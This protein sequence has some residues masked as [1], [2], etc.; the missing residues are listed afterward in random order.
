MLAPER[1]PVI[2]GVG[3]VTVP[4]DRDAE[5]SSRPEPLDLMVRALERAAEDASGAERGGEAKAGRQLLAKLDALYAVTGFAWH[6]KNPA[7]LVAE[8]LG[9][10]PKLLGLTA[11]GGNMPQ[12]LVHQ[13]SLSITRGELEAAAVVGAECLW[14]R[15]AARRHGGHVAWAVQEDPACPEP[16]AFG[17]EQAGS[18][19]LEVE[20]GVFLPLQAYP[21]IEQAFRARTGRSPEEHQRELGKL[22]GRFAQ[23]AAAN[24]HAWIRSAPSPEEIVTPS[25]ANRM[26][27][28]P[29]TKT[30][31]ANASVDQ[32]AG[33][34]ICSLATARAAGVPEDRMVFPRSGSDANDHWYL[35]H[36]VDLGRSP[37]IE[38][39]ARN[40]L[41]TAGLTLDDV[42]LVDLYSCFPCAVELACEA[43]GLDPLDPRRAP[44]LTGGLTFMGGPGNNYVSH[45]IAAMADALRSRGEGVGL[46]TG[47]GWYATKHSAGIY[48]TSPDERE[49]SAFAWTDAQPEVNALPQCQ[50]AG[51]MEGDVTVETYTVTYGRDG[52]PELGVL[53][54]R[55]AEGIRG[56]GNVRDVEGMARMEVEDLLG[57]P[58]RISADGSLKLS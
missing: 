37:A 32:G 23:V 5:L 33:F 27:S 25:E 29:Y 9:V 54:V 51:D 36:R 21:L 20:R 50:V 43:I 18:T 57:V 55:N 24:P 2:V 15:G 14:T 11:T 46:V 6:T 31:T 7:A 35:S 13:L 30:M 17:H 39:N 8:R 42:D 53:A 38:A 47:L 34:I 40:A 22:W 19:E 48:A 44:T 12:A 3:Q 58:A 1:I 56:W 26:V 4:G 41:S 52:A 10:E 16:V 45:S 28:L 49:G